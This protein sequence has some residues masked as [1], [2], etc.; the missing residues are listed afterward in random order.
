M[1]GKRLEKIFYDVLKVEKTSNLNRKNC[2]AWDSL[3]H[4]KLIAAIEEE[5]D[6][7]FNIEDLVK[8]NSF[9]DILSKVSENANIKKDRW[10][11]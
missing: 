1:T 10:F 7:E 8:L 6:L 11:I 9:D 4:I 3:N 2:P 5:F